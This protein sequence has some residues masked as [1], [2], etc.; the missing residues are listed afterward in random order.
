M[1]ARSNPVT[2][3]LGSRLQFVLLLS[4]IFVLLL[5][6]SDSKDPD[7]TPSSLPAEDV[8]KVD[9][10]I[11]SSSYPVR[12]LTPEAI[13]DFIEANGPANSKGE[14]GSGLAS[15]QWSYV[16]K[17]R[18]MERAC[19]LE[20]MTISL[21]LEV[22]LP[23]HEQLSSLPAAVRPYW[24]AFAAGVAQHE[25]R[26][27]DIYVDGARKIESQM[28]DLGR[29]ESCRALELRIGEVWNQEQARIDAQ[30]EAFH[31][32][33]D[34]RLAAVRRPLEVQIDSNRRRLSTL[35]NDIKGLDT[36]LQNLRSELGGI[37]AQRNALK[38]QM[39]AIQA[40]NPNGLPPQTFSQYETL[41]QQHDSQTARYNSVVQQHN[42][43][44]DRRDST[45]AEYDRLLAQTK[46]LVDTYNW[47]R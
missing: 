20:S 6:C 11:T 16:W 29:L 47:T 17:G 24:D 5:G 30:Q 44:I 40:A 32:E 34:K 23:Q 10:R 8:V 27:V 15:A 45:S 19:E 42:G 38:A 4:L 35:T 2:P 13:F 43:L 46:T 12:G 18:N 9:T 25:Q 37:E 28:S 39:D 3:P 1:E 31:V 33:E 14:R 7:P 21:L 22:V 41:R 36:S 26:H